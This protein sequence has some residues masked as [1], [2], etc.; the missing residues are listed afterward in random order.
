MDC[1]LAMRVYV[2]LFF[3]FLGEVHFKSGSG[4]HALFTGPTDLFFNKAF[5]K[6]ESHSIIH[7]FKNYF[8]II[9]SIFS[10]QQNK[11]YSNAHLVL[12]H[13]K[14]MTCIIFIAHDMDTCYILFSKGDFGGWK[15]KGGIK[16]FWIVHLF[17]W[18]AI[19]VEFGY[20]LLK[21][22]ISRCFVLNLYKYYFLSS[23][24]Y[25]QSNK[26]VFHHSTFL[27]QPKTHKGKV[28]LHLDTNEKWKLFD[29]LA[30]FCYYSWVSLYYFS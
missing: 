16:G 23:H 19:M 14:K 22:P 6:N 13:N 11:R 28:S 24:F 1:V 7:T 5:I 25:F 18:E 21:V 12:T 30:Y 27:S 20:F 9:F 17:G 4:S 10:F 15:L 26:R 8:A 3:F 29:Y 2:W